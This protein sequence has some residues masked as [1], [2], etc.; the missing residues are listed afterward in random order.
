MDQSLP[1]G[2]GRRRRRRRRKRR[3][4]SDRDPKD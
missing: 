4:G 1:R 3:L 2:G